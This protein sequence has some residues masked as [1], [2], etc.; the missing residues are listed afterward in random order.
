MWCDGNEYPL[1]LCYRP[2]MCEIEM[3]LKTNNATCRRRGPKRKLRAGYRALSLKQTLL[4]CDVFYLCG[5]FRFCR[6]LHR[7]GIPWRKIAHSVSHSLTHSI[8]YSMR[9]EPKLSL[10]NIFS[11]SFNGSG[12]NDYVDT[13]ALGV[14]RLYN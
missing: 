5:K 10:R 6:G 9:W 13:G 4:C 14:G 7:S 11:L 1:D 8:A 2:T 3:R 12:I